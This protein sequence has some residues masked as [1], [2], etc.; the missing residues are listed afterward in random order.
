MGVLEEIKTNNNEESCIPTAAI[1]F[2]R[3][4]S[5]FSLSRR[6]ANS[7]NDFVELFF[8]LPSQAWNI[9]SLPWSYRGV[10]VE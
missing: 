6:A 8:S 4:F 3:S 2:L 1:N 7:C 9:I 10:P 5:S